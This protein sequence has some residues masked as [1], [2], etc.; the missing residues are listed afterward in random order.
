MTAGHCTPQMGAVDTSFWAAM[1][2]ANTRHAQEYGDP[3]YAALSGCPSGDT[4]R[5]SDAAQ[6][7]WIDTS[8][9]YGLGL[10]ATPSGA[11]SVW[12]GTHYGPFDLYGY[13]NIIGEASDSWLLVNSS[14]S[15]VGQTSALTQG[16][17][18]A[19]CVTYYGN[20]TP[21]KDILC[22]MLTSMPAESGDSGSPVILGR[23]LPQ[24]TS[25]VYLAGVV[26][27]SDF[28]SSSLFSSIGGI[29]RDFGSL[30][31]YPTKPCC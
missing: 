30:Q 28:S 19:S 25:S 11:D 20:P 4:C 22:S 8:Q 10:I 16:R 31:T 27:A 13:F 21:G 23:P 24:S 1:S 7:N 14:V 3:A 26:M 15:K 6:F 5:N 29:A 17:V 12:G 9:T 18:T 2:Y